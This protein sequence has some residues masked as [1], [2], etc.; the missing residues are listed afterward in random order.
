LIDAMASAATNVAG[1]PAA[2][3]F[4]T[5]TRPGRINFSSV[6]VPGA[7][8]SA[9]A[10]QAGISAAGINMN[11][12][13]RGSWVSEIPVMG[14]AKVAWSPVY[15]KY[16][17]PGNTLF[18]LN[19]RQM[20]DKQT[21]NGAVYAFN[22][23]TMNAWLREMC[24]HAQQ[25]VAEDASDTYKALLDEPEWAWNQHM[26]ALTTD[27]LVQ[28]RLPYLT[29]A[30]IMGLVYYLGINMTQS[31]L[32]TSAYIADGSWSA[33]DDQ[34]QIA[35]VAKGPARVTH[36]V[37]GPDAVC[38]KHLWLQLRLVA[39]ERHPTMG[40]FRTAGVFQFVPYVSRDLTPTIEAAR[41]RYT[42]LTG[43]A[44]PAP[45]VYVGEVLSSG[46]QLVRDMSIVNQATG[47]HGVDLEQ[48]HM[49]CQMLERIEIAAYT[50]R[51]GSFVAWS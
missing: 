28:G 4:G 37:W 43:F 10:P 11:T 29:A 26:M 25:M 20:A 13:H 3:S 34:T 5:T 1:A 23:Y 50:Q 22:L 35:W 31:N 51:W 42:G 21:R 19:G 33:Q 49:A 32:M 6:P 27:R 16:L 12:Q 36:N 2:A 48:A 18:V 40:G 47:L 38:G 17:E 8:Y 14:N 9:P 15:T 46:R 24:R 45:A 39:D 44:E 30:G 7:A 41:R